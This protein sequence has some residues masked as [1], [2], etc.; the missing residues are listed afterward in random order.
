MEHTF[1][2]TGSTVQFSVDTKVYPRIAILK[3][4]Y[5]FIEKYYIFLSMDSSSLLVDM[6][7]KD[8]SSVD[9]Q[10][11]GNF[12]NELL[13]QLLRVQI[14]QNTKNIRELIMARALH[15]TC[16]ETEDSP[17]IESTE[18]NYFHIDDIAED[19]FAQQQE[20]V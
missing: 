9:E 11:V 1:K 12:Y 8:K 2:V 18:E 7:R 16:L 15:H 14:Y 6:K 10:D 3:T 5:I 13:N 4:A 19:W 20:E 17:T